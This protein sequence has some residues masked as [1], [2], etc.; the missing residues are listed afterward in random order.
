[1]KSSFFHID[2]LVTGLTRRREMSFPRSDLGG[3]IIFSGSEIDSRYAIISAGLGRAL[4]Y[5]TI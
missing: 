3:Y 5:R 1:V 4:L 2:N